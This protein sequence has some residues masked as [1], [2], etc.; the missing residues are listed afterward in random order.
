MINGNSYDWESM[1][2][3]LPSGVSCA[4]TNID[5]D[6]EQQIEE[7]YGRGATP[8]GY[9]RKNYKATAKME[10]DL[11]EFERLRLALGGSVYDGLPFQ[12]VVSY[13]PDMMPVVIDSLPACKIV[14]VSTGAK[15]GDDSVGVRK[16]DLKLLAPIIWNGS[17]AK[18][19]I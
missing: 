7:R 11:E 13:A 4:V 6:D 2:I 3:L 15:Q 17:P 9:G 19:L 5:Y 8:R 12:I 10:M 16:V 1:E 18:S 14:K